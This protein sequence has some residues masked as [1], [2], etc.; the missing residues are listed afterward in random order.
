MSIY[1]DRCTAMTDAQDKN[2]DFRRKALHLAGSF[3]DA[4][5]KY[6]GAPKS[7][8]R[9]VDAQKTNSP[10]VSA[11]PVDENGDEYRSDTPPLA[12]MS[13]TPDSFYRFKL[14]LVHESS[15]E[16]YPKN[17]HII[18]C[19]VRPENDGSCKLF[20]E[21]PGIPQHRVFHCPALYVRNDGKAFICNYDAPVKYY[22]ELVKSWFSFDP[23][24]AK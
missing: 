8:V 3:A 16:S 17:L 24:E 20:V 10:Y 2:E 12:A 15:T 11:V 9:D 22:V 18:P 5:H 6:F 13:F 4:L 19:G 14:V 7:W 21:L 23:F 1:S